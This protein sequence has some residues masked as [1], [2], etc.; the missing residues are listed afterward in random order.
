MNREN[1][2]WI[3]LGLVLLSLYFSYYMYIK[4]FDN[5]LVEGL[6]NKNPS[7]DKSLTVNSKSA[8]KSL[9]VKTEALGNEL[10][11]NKYEYNDNYSKMCTELYDIVNLKMVKLALSLDPNG[12]DAIFIKGLAELNT[13]SQSKSTLNGIVEFIDGIETD[14]NKK[15][16]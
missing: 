4:Y 1:E 16:S 7:N 5:P 3:L 8:L 11:L 9:T 13:M 15:N 6:E 10:L 14:E 12:S 2:E